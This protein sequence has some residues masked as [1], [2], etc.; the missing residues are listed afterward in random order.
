M[1]QIRIFQEVGQLRV[2]A[3]INLTK[4]CFENIIIIVVLEIGQQHNTWT[5]LVKPNKFSLT[6]EVLDPPNFSFLVQ[7]SI[8]NVELQFSSI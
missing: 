5:L 1:C 7:N 8:G 6:G 3:I 2:T 4:K